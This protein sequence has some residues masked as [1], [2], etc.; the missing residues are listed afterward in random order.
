MNKIT[1]R[2]AELVS[3]LTENRNNHRAVV[4]DAWTGY[5]KEAINTLEAQLDRA[6]KG[7]KRNLYISLACPSDHT[8]DYDRALQMLKMD[9]SDEVTL[10]EAEFANYV[11]D[12]WGWSGQWAT[13]N[14][15][16]TSMALPGLEDE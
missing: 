13:T 3:V 5:R 15:S 11:Q 14:A 6:R 10:T 9:V 12:N 7:L 16:Y 4:E 1:V 8:E 2:K